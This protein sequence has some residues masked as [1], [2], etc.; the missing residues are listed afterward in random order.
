MKPRCILALLVVIGLSFNAA[1]Q[2]AGVVRILT[3]RSLFGP[4]VGAVVKLTPVL[5][6]SGELRIQLFPDRIIGDRRYKS[7]EEA[8]RVASAI[9]EKSRELPGFEAMTFIDDRAIHV[10]AVAREAHFLAPRLRM[11]VVVKELG[12]PEKTVQLLIDNG[13]EQ[14][15]VVLD[16]AIYAGGAIGFATKR[17]TADPQAVNRVFLDTRRIST[18]QF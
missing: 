5:A 2:T 6:A 14:R 1:A 4:D 17:G 18:E 10:A 3:N 15:P 13:T 7:A 9:N 16:V 12:P 11:D 8:N